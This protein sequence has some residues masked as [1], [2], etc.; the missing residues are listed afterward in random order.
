LRFFE[1]VKDVDS[2]ARVLRRPFERSHL[3]TGGQELTARHTQKGDNPMLWVPD[4]DVVAHVKLKA[5]K[6]KQLPEIDDDLAREV[7][8]Y[9]TLDELKES[10]RRTVNYIKELSSAGKFTEELLDAAGNRAESLSFPPVLVEEEID[11]LVAQNTRRLAQ[12]EV[13]LERY[14]EPFAHTVGVMQTP[15]ALHRVA[16]ECAEDLAAETFLRRVVDGYPDEPRVVVSDKLGSYVP[17]LKKV[18]PRTE[19]RKHKGLNNRAEN[20]HQPT[21]QRERARG[22]FKSPM[23]AQR[24]LEPFGPIREHFCPRRHRLSARAHRAIFA[25]RFAT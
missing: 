15:A 16:A 4:Q 8:D 13:S 10:I 12:Q 24:C 19:H 22:R 20:S 17:A 3:L 6:E 18:L 2:N 14:L 23:N 11:E 1:S 21:R 9:N 25:D 7:G 5:I